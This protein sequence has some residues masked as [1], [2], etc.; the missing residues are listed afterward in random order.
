MDLGLVALG[1]R[2]PL[3][4]V[5]VQAISAGLPKHTK[6]LD[7]RITEIG[8]ASRVLL[9]VRVECLGLAVRRLAAMQRDDPEE[10]IPDHPVLAPILQLEVGMEGLEA[11]VAGRE[12]VG[13]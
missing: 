6:M 12:V 9:V 11:V 2:L 4:A 13:C 10:P 5:A 7:L 3:E 8:V 1:C